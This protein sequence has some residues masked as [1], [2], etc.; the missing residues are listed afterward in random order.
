MTEQT[1]RTVTFQLGTS[2]TDLLENVEKSDDHAFTQRLN[3]S[4]QV[5]YYAKPQVALW[6]FSF[7]S[8]IANKLSP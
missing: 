1:G 3:P 7:A 6:S 2:N 8:T 5:P 4:V